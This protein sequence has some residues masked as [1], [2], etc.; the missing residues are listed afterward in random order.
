MCDHDIK[1]TSKQGLSLTTHMESSFRFTRSSSL[2]LLLWHLLYPL[3]YFTSLHS[4]WHSKQHALTLIILVY[5]V[6]LL[7]LIYAFSTAF[8][9]GEIS[10]GRDDILSPTRKKMCATF[11]AWPDFVV[12]FFFTFFYSP[13]SHCV[14]VSLFLMQQMKFIAVLNFARNPRTI[15]WRAS[16]S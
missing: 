1:Q 16:H 5:N 11:C 6:T 3:I 8:L 12:V 10:A 4:S 14:S 9:F 13:P 7:F 2:L 15:T